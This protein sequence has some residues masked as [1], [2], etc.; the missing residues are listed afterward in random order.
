MKPGFR[1]VIWAVIGL[2]FASG[3]SAFP[4]LKVLSGQ[5]GSDAAAISVVQ[6]TGLVMGDKTGL[7]DPA[8]SAAAD[9]IEAA[10]NGNVDIVEIRKDLGT[11]VFV[12]YM[13]LRPPGQNATQADII[14]EI[15]RAIE[16]SWQGTMTQSLGANV[17]RIVLLDPTPVPTLDKGISFVGFV[18]LD[19]EISRSDAILYL[20]HRPNTLN[21]FAGLV[22]EGKLKW[23]Q[24]TQTEFYQG[25]PNHAV[26]MLSALASQIQGQDQSNQDSGNSSQNGS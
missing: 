26:F 22:A 11:D 19:T 17:L 20:N 15:R 6:T 2:V 13:L 23:T 10:N 14:N 16:L 4:G 12:I 1:V 24:P 21:D 9:R 18:G 8:L 3:C 25:T 5:A 7:T